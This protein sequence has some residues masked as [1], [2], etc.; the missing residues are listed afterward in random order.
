[1]PWP[2]R[3]VQGQAPGNSTL[4]SRIRTFDKRGSDRPTACVRSGETL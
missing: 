3:P 2:A 4:V 1:M